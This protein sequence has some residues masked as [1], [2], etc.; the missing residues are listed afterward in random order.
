MSFFD[1]LVSELEKVCIFKLVKET[2]ADQ[3]M[4]IPYTNINTISFEEDDEDDSTV[5]VSQIT[6]NPLYPYP[7]ILQRG[8]NVVTLTEDFLSNYKSSIIQGAVA[9]ISEA[10]IDASNNHFGV[11]FQNGKNNNDLD[12]QI[13]QLD[14][15]SP[16][17][18]CVL[19]GLHTIQ[20]QKDI[21]FN[22][23]LS[24]IR[25]S[26]VL[27]RHN[28]DFDKPVIS[29]PRRPGQNQVLVFNLDSS[30]VYASPKF[31]IDNKNRLIFSFKVGNTSPNWIAGYNL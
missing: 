16:T 19:G 14:F 30:L 29:F 6:Y 8:G 18:V 5:N 10:F 13:S 24:W 26:Y 2:P 4:A 1:D 11:N 12:R 15:Y 28:Y 27:H 17:E 31:W 22:S 21:F 25:S 20:S 9:A 3:F 7:A 23:K